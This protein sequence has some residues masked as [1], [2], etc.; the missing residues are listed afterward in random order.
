MG[1][2]AVEREQWEVLHK[3]EKVIVGGGTSEMGT[4]VTQEFT[5]G[6]YQKEICKSL[7]EGGQTCGLVSSW[8]VWGSLVSGQAW[9]LAFIALTVLGQTNRDIFQSTKTNRDVFQSII[10]WL[11]RLLSSEEL[12]K[13]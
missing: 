7:E 8:T 6:K 13:D 9:P 11:L 5:K 4:L 1:F 10:S 3:G 2:S 12:F